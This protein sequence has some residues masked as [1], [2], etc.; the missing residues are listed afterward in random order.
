VIR[1]YYCF[2]STTYQIADDNGIAYLYKMKSPL[3]I[4][5]EWRAWDFIKR[6]SSF[7]EA[8]HDMRSRLSIHD[9]DRMAACEVSEDEV[10][11]S[12]ENYKSSNG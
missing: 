7:D 5:S 4:T 10:L 12:I 6:Y 1:K 11:K 9:S 2:G 8:F 3:S